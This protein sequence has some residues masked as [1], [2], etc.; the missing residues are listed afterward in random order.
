VGSEESE[1]A[2]AFRFFVVAGLEAGQ[3]DGLKPVAYVEVKT[4]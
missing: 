2:S 3:S 4:L 1:L